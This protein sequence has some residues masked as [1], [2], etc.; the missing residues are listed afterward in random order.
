VEHPPIKNNLGDSSTSIA[1]AMRKQNLITAIRAIST[2][3]RVSA[4]AVNVEISKCL[5]NRGA[6]VGVLPS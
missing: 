5:Y 1:A 3:T 6:Y 4:R 2:P